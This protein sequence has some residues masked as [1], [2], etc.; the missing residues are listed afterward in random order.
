[1]WEWLSSRESFLLGF[2]F[3]LLTVVNE[4]VG[5]S[6]LGAR[7]SWK[8]GFRTFLTYL[9]RGFPPTLSAILGPSGLSWLLVFSFRSTASDFP[10]AGHDFLFAD[11]QASCET[12]TASN[13]VCFPCWAL[14]G[15][16]GKWSSLKA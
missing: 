5:Y 14:T 2:V 9:V 6:L 3:L 8:Q 7:I 12:L 10:I 16:Q 11:L 1:M 15:A 13:S 4:G